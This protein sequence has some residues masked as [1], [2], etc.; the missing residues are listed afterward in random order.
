MRRRLS[1]VLVVALALTC[2]AGTVNASPWI[3]IGFEEGINPDGTINGWTMTQDP[4]ATYGVGRY[5]TDYTDVT[6][7]TNQSAYAGSYFL[8]MK[9]GGEHTDITATQSAEIT[10]ADAGRIMGWYALRGDGPPQSAGDKVGVS[11]TLSGQG[12][13]LFSGQLNVHSTDWLSWESDLLGAGTYTLTYTVHNNMQTASIGLFDTY[14]SVAE[15]PV[16]PEPGTLALLGA[17]LALPTLR[18]R[19][20]TKAAKR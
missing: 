18:R 20:A 2:A 6:L 17:G 12:G 13:K 5:G 16:T 11:F 4:G 10:L 19:R 14:V 8:W 9:A 1:L 7:A 3:N 15:T